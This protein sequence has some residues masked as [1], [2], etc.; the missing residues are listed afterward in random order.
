MDLMLRLAT[1]IFSQSMCC[2]TKFYADQKVIDSQEDAGTID[3]TE[4]MN[5]LFDSMN[6]R[7][8]QKESKMAAMTSP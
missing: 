5:D 1:Q 6:R 3:I 2:S 7:H 4:R 8:R